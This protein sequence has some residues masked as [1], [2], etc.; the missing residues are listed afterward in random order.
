MSDA[1]A[2]ADP[3]SETDADEIPSG[4]RPCKISRRGRGNILTGVRRKSLRSPRSESK[5]LGSFRALRM[6]YLILTSRQR[7]R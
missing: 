2:R 6:N 1:D 7:R 4:G 3:I 5:A